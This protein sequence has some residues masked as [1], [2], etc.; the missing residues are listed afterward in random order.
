MVVSF[1]V[2][3]FVVSLLVEEP[4]ILQQP[5]YF[6]YTLP[7]PVASA[8]IKG[9]GSRGRALPAGHKVIVTLKLLTPESNFNLQV[10]TEAISSTGQV[11][12]AFS[13]PCMLRF[14]SLPVRLMKTFAMA[15][16]LLIGVQT[17]TQQLVLEVL[18]YKEEFRRTDAIKVRLTPRAGTLDLPQIYHAEILLHTQL[19]R[20]KEVVYNWKWTL[21]VW[22]SLYIYVL[23]LIVV[24]CCF[25]PFDFLE[26]RAEEVAEA[27]QYRG[28]GRLEDVKVSEKFTEAVS[29][30]RGME[31][32]R[33]RIGQV[34]Q[35]ELVE[36]SAS[37]AAGETSQ[38]IEAYAD[39]AASEIAS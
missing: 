1:L 12:A 27:A 23:L 4:V 24:F 37:S 33:R 5:L 39:C 32:R 29:R 18:S 3:F 6:D 15:L 14:K 28:H 19:P 20:R 36:G 17:E 2:G 22:A 16:P 30:W 26:A 25:K 31:R 38:A 9:A 10:S 7:Q 21:C 34:A 11:I 35:R 8:Q 13:Q